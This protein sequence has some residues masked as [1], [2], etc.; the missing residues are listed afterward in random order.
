MRWVI[1]SLRSYLTSAFMPAAGQGRAARLKRNG[2]G[3]LKRRAGRRA[4]S[5]RPV[6]RSPARSTWSSM[7]SPRIA[8]SRHASGRVR[9]GLERTSSRGAALRRGRDVLKD[10]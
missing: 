7:L 5:R 2:A 8:A 1:S 3:D 4:K 6:P 10:S 9:D